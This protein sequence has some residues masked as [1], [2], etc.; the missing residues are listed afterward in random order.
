LDLVRA[1]FGARLDGRR[2]LKPAGS[3]PGFDLGFDP[4]CDLGFD[5]GPGIPEAPGRA[6]A[7]S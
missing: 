6:A 3:D 4:G 1:G 5:L 7:R 2:D